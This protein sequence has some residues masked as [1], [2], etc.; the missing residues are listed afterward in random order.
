MAFDR[1]LL[2]G[3]AL[4][5]AALAWP[6]VGWPQAVRPLVPLLRAVPDSVAAPASDLD[7]LVALALARNPQTRAAVARAGAAD[8]R[9]GPAGARPDPMLMAGI[10]AF[11]YR[12]PGFSDDFTMNVV[13]LTQTF[14]Y[15]GKLSLATR[16]AEDDAAAAGAALEQTRLDVVRDVKT[17]YYEL[18]YVSRARAIVA[19]SSGL[20]AGLAKAAEGRYEVGTASQADVLRARVA[21]ARLGDQA[22]M[23][24]AQ[25]RTALARLNA[26]LDQPSDTPV[27][28]DMPPALTR[29]AGPDSA[30]DVR[31][32]SAALGAAPGDSPLLG[33]DSLVALALTHS[34]LLRAR[35][36][37]ISAQERRLALAEKA[38]LPDFDISLE[39]DQ[40]PRFPDYLSFF[41]SIPLRLQRGRKQ[42]QQAVEAGAELTALQAERAADVNRVRER[43]ASLTANAER[44]RTELALSR[45]GILPQARGL[46]ASAT[47]SYEVGRLDLPVVLDAQAELFNEETAYARALMDF[48]TAL[49]ELESVVG[50][51]VVR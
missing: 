36:R 46:V 42:G 18:A 49:A 7:S 24:T 31:F 17:A 12:Q 28:A 34:P 8:A 38:H 16:A 27:S 21:A 15:P 19:R 5:W 9:I 2:S 48:A 33:V 44:A 30:A 43:I 3:V 50:A 26:L 22:A 11:P 4:A 6:A 35:E 1:S 13:R 29:L 14:P 40:R 23:L 37:Q 51:E 39:Y 45:K 41:V 25:E 32:A 10:V 20:L 47:A